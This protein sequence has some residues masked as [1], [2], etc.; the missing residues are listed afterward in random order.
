MSLIAKYVLQIRMGINSLAC[1]IYL[2]RALVR[3][4]LFKFCNLESMTV[5]DRTSRTLRECP[6]RGVRNVGILRKC[7]SN[8]WN[9]QISSF[10]NGN[11]NYIRNVY[12]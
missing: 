7:K 9:Q 2:F 11:V 12:I 5:S 6:S 10:E 3:G 4:H 1:F 8:I